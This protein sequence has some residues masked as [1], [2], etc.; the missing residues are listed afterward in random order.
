[1]SVN[2]NIQDCPY[3]DVRLLKLLSLCLQKSKERKELKLQTRMLNPQN[4]NPSKPAEMNGV[5]GFAAVGATSVIVE[6]KNDEFS[7]AECNGDANHNR[8]CDSD[9]LHSSEA[10]PHLNLVKSVNK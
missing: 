3:A 2:T 8:N 4:N 6:E 1:V 5:N 9:A 10:D 7:D